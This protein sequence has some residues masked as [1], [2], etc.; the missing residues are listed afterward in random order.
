MGNKADLVMV[1]HSLSLTVDNMNASE[2]SFILD[3]DT[4]HAALLLIEA[5]ERFDKDDH[6]SIFSEPL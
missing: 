2:L 6:P 3:I 5:A 1:A 4:I